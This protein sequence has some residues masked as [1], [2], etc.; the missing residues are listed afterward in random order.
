MQPFAS[1]K[2]A[3]CFERALDGDFDRIAASF[4]E[5]A[6]AEGGVLEL[7]EAML[8]STAGLD[9]R[10]VAVMLDDVARLAELGRDPLIN[11]ITRYPRDE[12]GLPISVDVHSFHVDRAPVETDTFLC[13]YSGASSELLDNDDATRLFDDGEVL[14]ALRNLDISDEGFELHFRPK[15]GAV[16]IS[17]GIGLL[18]RLAVDWPGSP[19]PPCIHRAPVPDGRPRLLLIA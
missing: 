16:P 8:R 6:D 14:E 2:N 17:L 15:P 10:A 13:T 11:V 9:P 3:H 19:V 4:A 5:R 12:R 1:G 18:W 7:D